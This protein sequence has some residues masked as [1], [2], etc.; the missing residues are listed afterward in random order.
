MKSAL[1]FD[2]T[3][4]IDRAATNLLQEL[5][6]KSTMVINETLMHQLFSP[7]KDPPATKE[8]P[9]GFQ[10]PTP[11]VLPANSNFSIGLPQR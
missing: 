11:Q 3:G 1:D 4:V 6:P 2:D 10:F 8:V 9:V 5:D 7:R